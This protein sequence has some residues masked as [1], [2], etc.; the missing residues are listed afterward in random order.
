MTH[1]TGPT[2]GEGFASR[3]GVKLDAALTSFG[4]DP[5][6]LTCADL[7]CSTG[8]FTD[9]LIQRGAQR[10]YAVDTAYGELAWKLRQHDRVTVLERTNALHFDPRE[11]LE[12][13]TGAD[14]VSID[15]GWTKQQRAIPAAIRWL[16]RDHDQPVGDVIALIKPHY[17][18][19]QHKLDDDEAER[20]ARE[21]A[22]GLEDDHVKLG[23]VIASP[24]RGGKGKNLEFL[25]HIKV[26]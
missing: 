17:E 14:L 19:G 7:G 6:G 16:K 2:R 12:G 20:I 8:G 4:V 3:A 15:L 1:T 25:T 21:V 23:G 13:F 10:V 22:V 5:A 18:S 9:C 26:R 11:E 24:V